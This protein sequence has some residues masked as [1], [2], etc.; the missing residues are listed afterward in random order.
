MKPCGCRD[1]CGYGDKNDLKRSAA[2]IGQLR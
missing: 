1:A 2:L